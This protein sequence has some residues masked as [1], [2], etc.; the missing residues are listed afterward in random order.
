MTNTIFPGARLFQ[1][2]ATHGVPLDISL[3]LLFHRCQLRVDWQGFV[4]EAR[5]NHWWDFQTLE[6]IQNALAEVLDHAEQQA[7]VLRL[8]RYMLENPLR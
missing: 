5:R 7:I 8:K 3:D 6:V 2:K 4:D 1:I